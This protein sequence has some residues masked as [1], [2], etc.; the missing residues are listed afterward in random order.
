MLLGVCVSSV[1]LAADIRCKRGASPGAPITDS[2]PDQ[3]H[4][5]VVD[6]THDDDAVADDIDLSR[7][8]QR[9][10]GVVAPDL[11]SRARSMAI[12]REIFGEPVDAELLDVARTPPQDLSGGLD[13]PAQ[14]RLSLRQPAAA[15][16]REETVTD[17]PV[18]GAV[19]VPDS[20][21]RLPGV[22]SEENLRY[23]RQMYRT[24][25]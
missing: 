24:D 13:E 1:S 22:S 18:D 6:L 21:A 16:E 17:G 9:E 10:R 19:E 20:E 14:D 2:L 7:E 12:L 4:I 11:S 8:W 15:G 5:D 3:L 23:R 25:I